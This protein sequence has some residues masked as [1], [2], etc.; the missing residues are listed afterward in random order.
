[1]FNKLIP[2]FIPRKVILDLSLENAPSYHTKCWC[3][4]CKVSRIT[5]NYQRYCCNCG[6]KLSWNI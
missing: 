6:Q 5:W 4:R 3:P 1:M 2:K